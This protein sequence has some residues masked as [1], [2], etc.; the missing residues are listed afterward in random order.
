VQGG[1]EHGDGDGEDGVHRDESGSSHSWL[2]R[3]FG[4]VNFST[5]LR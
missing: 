1:R 2:A 4:S 5:S 3:V